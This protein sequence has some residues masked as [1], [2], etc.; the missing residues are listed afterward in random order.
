MMCHSARVRT[1]FV[2]VTSFLLSFAAISMP[3][4]L[5][6]CSAAGFAAALPTVAEIVSDGVAILSM[7]STAVETYFKN[8]PGNTTQQ[9]SIDAA[10]QKAQAALVAGGQALSG[11]QNLTAGQTAAAFA[12]FSQAYAD[13]MA[14]VAPLGI[15]PAQPVADGGALLAKA[16]PSTF[17]P[18]PLA[19]RVK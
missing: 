2:L 14:L 12:S 6:G 16:S 7:V 17:I 13:L 11:V 3:V 10:I 4:A 5:T 9:A 1:I 8:H 15:V 19:L 18:T